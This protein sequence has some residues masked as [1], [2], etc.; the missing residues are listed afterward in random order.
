MQDSKAVFAITANS[1]KQD[2][3]AAET[4]HDE[5]GSEADWVCEDESASSS[6]SEEDASEV[7]GPSVRR[8]HRRSCGRIN[9]VAAPARMPA[10]SPA[11]APAP[12]PAATSPEAATS[13]AVAPV[14]VWNT[15]NAGVEVADMRINAVVLVFHKQYRADVT[16][17]V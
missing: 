11:S 13:P 6:D 5:C 7:P 2:S 14:A 15:T 8:G 10:T 17:G 1:T 16:E 12:D 4:D 9:P 3:D